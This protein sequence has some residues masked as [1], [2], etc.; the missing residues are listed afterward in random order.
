MQD[1]SHT[2]W[3]IR[4]AVRM[5]PGELVVVT[6]EVENGLYG[7][8]PGVDLFVAWQDGITAA[9]AERFALQQMSEMCAALSREAQ[10]RLK[11]GEN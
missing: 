4:T 5:K 6:V 1:A 9:A 7:E 10:R 11:S 2:D 8:M 3:K